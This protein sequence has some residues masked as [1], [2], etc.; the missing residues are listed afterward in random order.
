MDLI[1][2]VH[3]SK[4]GLVVVDVA[5][6]DDATAFTFQ[7]ELAARW[8]TA[9]ADRTTRDPGQSGVRLRRYLD[10]GQPLGSGGS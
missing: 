10:V 3:V 4:P 5:A 8:A 6:V 9:M 1:N 2:E 7:Q